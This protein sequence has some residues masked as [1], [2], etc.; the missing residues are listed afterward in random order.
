MHVY[1]TWSGSKTDPEY[2]QKMI[3]IK[4]KAVMAAKKP[5]YLKIVLRIQKVFTRLFNSRL[6]KGEPASWKLSLIRPIAKKQVQTGLKNLAI[7]SALF[8]TVEKVLFI[9]LSTKVTNMLDLLQFANKSDRS[10]EDLVLVLPDSVSKQLEL[11]KG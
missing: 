7:T 9:H 1:D 3:F 5:V 2:K 4:Q 8:K 6:T 11:T 10:T